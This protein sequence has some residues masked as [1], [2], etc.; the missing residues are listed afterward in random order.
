[1]ETG[2]ERGH[3]PEITQGQHGNEAHPPLGVLGFF[4][5]FFIVAKYA[6]Y[7]MYHLNHF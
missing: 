6:Q 4:S 3:T 1:M 7:K 2:D 5:N